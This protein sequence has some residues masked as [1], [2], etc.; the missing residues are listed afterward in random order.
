LSE[1]LTDDIKSVTR[2]LYTVGGRDKSKIFVAIR[3]CLAYTNRICEQ[4]AS[5]RIRMRGMATIASVLNQPK[6]R[7]HRARRRKFSQGTI[8]RE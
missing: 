7:R 1:Q 4:F 5:E 6:V 3:R 2:L 8:K